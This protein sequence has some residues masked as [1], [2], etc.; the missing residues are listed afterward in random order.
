MFVN[1]TLEQLRT[2]SNGAFMRPGRVSLSYEITDLPMARILALVG[3]IEKTHSHLTLDHQGY[4]K[5]IA[6][7]SAP[8]SNVWSLFTEKDFDSA[9]TERLKRYLAPIEEVS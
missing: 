8:L 9:R 7:A 1:A 3:H 6:S 2:V 4:K 5:L